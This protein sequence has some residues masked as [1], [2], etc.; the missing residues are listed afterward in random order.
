MAH[1]DID[2]YMPVGSRKKNKEATVI[3]RALS[4][5]DKY[6]AQNNSGRF[7]KDYLQSLVLKHFFFSTKEFRKI[8]E[9][10]EDYRIS[11]VNAGQ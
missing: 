10:L 5:I 1:F 7:L 8:F 4:L 6:L 3:F 11:V 2:M 9:I